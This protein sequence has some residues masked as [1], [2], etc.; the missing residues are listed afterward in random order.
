M[1]APQKPVETPEQMMLRL[2]RKAREEG[3]ELLMESR[4]EEVF[5]TSGTMAGVCYR[6]DRDACS[7]KGFE[8]YRRCKHHGL[9][10]YALGVIV[11]PDPEPAELAAA[12][13]TLASYEALSSKNLLKTTADFMGLNRARQRVE[14]LAAANLPPVVT[15]IGAPVVSYA[16]D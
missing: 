9:Y 14:E 2:A 4:T 11:E 8:V 6:V 3:C 16:A 15:R 10:L 12:K 13:A 5:V 1:V 7:C